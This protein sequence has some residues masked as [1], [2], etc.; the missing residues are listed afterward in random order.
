MMRIRTML[1]GLALVL[2]AGIAALLGG[3]G[4]RWDWWTLGW[5]FGIVRWA[6]YAA[7]AGAAAGLIA[8]LLPPL[9]GQWLTRAGAAAIVVLG[10]GIVMPPWL[11]QQ[12]ADG[13]PPI[14]D[15]TTDT[16]NP[17]AFVAILPLRAG[18]NNPPDYPGADYGQRQHQS[19]PDIAPVRMSVP[20]AQAL[21]RAQTIAEAMGWA[22]VA[23]EP[24][25]GRIEAV[26]ETRWFGLKDDVVIRVA[27]DGGGSRVDIRSK[28]RIG[29]GDRGMNAWR[30][31]EFLRRMSA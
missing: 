8:I 24:G 7:L 4:Y 22:I 14:N 28:A 2:A 12:T 15:V 27:A 16:E 9:R 13:A 3:Y 29:R 6:A 17:P 18:S 11:A 25:A 1:T 26:A 5:G 30:V 23:V 10:L 21:T 20:P 19:L 31:R